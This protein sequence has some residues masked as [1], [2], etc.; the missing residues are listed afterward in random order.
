M[1]C[2]RCD[3]VSSSDLNEPSIDYGFHRLQKY[4]PRQPGDPERLSKETVLKRAADIAEALAGRGDALGTTRR[5]CFPRFS[6]RHMAGAGYINGN[7][8]GVADY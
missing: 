8:D 1:H 6:I 3:N 7:V 5:E 4:I 2:R